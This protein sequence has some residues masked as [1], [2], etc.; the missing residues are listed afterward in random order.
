MAALERPQRR[1]LHGIFGSLTQPGVCAVHARTSIPSVYSAS[2]SGASPNRAPGFEV[3]RPPASAAPV[4]ARH[5]GARLRRAYTPSEWQALVATAPANRTVVY[6]IAVAGGLR[7]SELAPPET[8]LH[9]QEPTTRW[10]LRPEV[11]KNRLAWNLP[12]LAECAQALLP[13][14]EQAS[15]P[16]S[17]LFPPTGQGGDHR[18]QPWRSPR[19]PHSIKT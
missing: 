14:W 7:R 11:S 9:P 19:L 17:P 1:F 13:L 16:E 12:M 3:T 10:H 6:Q 4:A 8:R 15:Q 18:E 5:N 2:G